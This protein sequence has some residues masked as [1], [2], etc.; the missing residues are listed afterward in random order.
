[1]PNK[2]EKVGTLRERIVIE[3]LS[4]AQSTSGHPAQS[5][6][7]LATVW[8]AVDYRQLPS[9]EKEMT[10]RKV[11]EQVVLFTVRYRSDVTEKHR[12]SYNSQYYDITS[13]AID[14]A[15]FYM[16]LEGQKRN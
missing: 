9:D 5:W 2:A 12:I 1:M 7:T 16:T 10:G 11:A 6:S 8:A 13:I 14:P 3:S 15:K 4:E